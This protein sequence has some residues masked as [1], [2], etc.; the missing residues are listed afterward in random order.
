MG[1]LTSLTSFANPPQNIVG[2]VLFLSYIIL[3]LYG[4]MAI[5]ISLWRQYNFINIQDSMKEEDRSR[6]KT[7]YD[8]RKRHISIYAFLA[9]I[10]FATL[11][12]HMSR[13][14]IHSYASWAGKVDVK[15]G[16]VTVESLKTWMWNT[17]LFAGFAKELVID[18]PSA[19]CTQRAILATYLWNIWMAQKSMMRESTEG[20]DS[21][22]IS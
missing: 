18:A 5:T 3:A 1:D 20:S 13:F 8:A 14:L 10:S 16:D 22:L 11:S 17:S 6:I 7:I 2:S 19:A 15:F 4:T 9:S 12:Y 21:I